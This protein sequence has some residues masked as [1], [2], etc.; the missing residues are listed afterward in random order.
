MAFAKAFPN[1][2]ILANITEFGKTPLYSVEELGAAGVSLV[3][4]PLWVF[5]VL[6]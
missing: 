6:F 1:T 4:Y 5:L 3:L 2:P